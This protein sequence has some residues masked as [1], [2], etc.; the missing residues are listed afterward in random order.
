MK[1]QQH[2]DG[3]DCDFCERKGVDA[4][5]YHGDKN[6]CEACHRRLVEEQRKQE[7]NKEGA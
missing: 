5:Y 7:R 1:T 2:E 6:A 4:V 3:W